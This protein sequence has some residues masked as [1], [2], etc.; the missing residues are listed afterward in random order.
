[1]FSSGGWWRGRGIVFEFEVVILGEGG[2]GGLYFWL[3]GGEH[4]G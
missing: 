3:R 1:V 4:L 2:G